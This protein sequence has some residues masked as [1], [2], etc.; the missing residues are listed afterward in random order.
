ML[1]RMAL[2]KII[3]SSLSLLLLLLFLIIPTNNKNNK[4]KSITYDNMVKVPVYLKGPNNYV[5]RINIDLKEQSIP[6]IIDLLTINNQNNILIPHGFQAVIPPNTKLIDYYIKDNILTLNFSQEFY[7]ISSNNEEI[8]IESLIYSLCELKDINGI[9]ILINGEKLN[10]LPHSNKILPTIL[11]YQYGINKIYDLNSL[12]ESKQTT[13]YY[14]SNY[15]NINYYI[16]ITKIN[17]NDHSKIEIIVNELRK[18]P[19]INANLSNY[20]K[21]SYE[22]KEYEILDNAIKLTFDNHLL[23]G[24]NDQNMEEELKY[25]LTLSIRDTYNIDNITINIS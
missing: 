22:L 18:T 10:N 9:N 24:L 23:A 12:K 21:A 4:E 11:D 2:R 19:Y 13:I 20:L 8:M 3:V 5:S 16:P 25:I 6:Y 15:E 7:N 17:N 14:L 1:R